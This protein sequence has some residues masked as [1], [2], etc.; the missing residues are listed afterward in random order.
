M[1]KSSVNAA[2][3]AVTEVTGKDQVA[4]VTGILSIIFAFT[5]PIAGVVL[6]VIGIVTHGGKDGKRNT[7]AIFGL[8][9]SLIVMIVVTIGTIILAVT[10]MQNIDSLTETCEERGPGRHR[11]GTFTSVT[12]GRDG[13][14]LDVD[15]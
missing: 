6:G 14:I 11:I 2:E 1:S 9:M 13:R 15:F 5:A 3:G 7:A 4:K 8:V 10:F 12:C